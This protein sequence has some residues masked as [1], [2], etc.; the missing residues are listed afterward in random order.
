MADMLQAKKKESHSHIIVEEPHQ[1]KLN[2]DV[3]TAAEQV[4]PVTY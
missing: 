4:P 1:F 3:S 2:E